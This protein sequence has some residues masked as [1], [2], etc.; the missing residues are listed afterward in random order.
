MAEA[1]QLCP[2][3]EVPHSVDD[4]KKKEAQ[5]VKRIAQLEREYASP[6]SHSVD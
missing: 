5:L 1:V 2:K 6:R 4:L 3:I